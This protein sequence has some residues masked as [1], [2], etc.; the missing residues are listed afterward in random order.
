MFTTLDCAVVLAASTIFTATSFA[1]S[2]KDIRGPSPLVAILV[3]LLAGVITGA[4][5]LRH[6]M[7]EAYAGARRR[8]A[9]ST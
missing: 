4:A 1:Q 5:Y 7:R 9:T 2:A 8:P 3:V 6:M